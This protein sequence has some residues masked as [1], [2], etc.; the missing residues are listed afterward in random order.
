VLPSLGRLT[1]R[2]DG[3][4]VLP[5]IAGA[6][7]VTATVPPAAPGGGGGA[8]PAVPRSEEPTGRLPSTLQPAQAN[9]G[10]RTVPPQS[11]LRAG[12]QAYNDAVADLPASQQRVATMSNA[13]TALAGATTGPAGKLQQVN[14]V[15]G[16]YAPEFIRKVIPGYDP[17]KAATDYDLAAKY[18]QQIANATSVGAGATTNDKLAA[19]ISANPNTHM[20]QLAAEE[21]LH[22]LMSQEKLGQYITKQAQAQNIAPAD[23]ARFRANWYATHDPRAALPLTPELSDYV[24]KNLK[25]RELQTF[26]TTLEELDRNGF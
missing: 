26:R 23:Y 11:A 13:L 15:L 7:S 14:R 8:A 12:E 10:G 16:T 24:R 1:P 6:P 19:A 20:T 2:P 25:G 18:M 21:V 3:S 5:P 22:V 9:R 4:L 17:E